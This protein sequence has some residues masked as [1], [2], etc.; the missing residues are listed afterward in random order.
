M[1]Q[2]VFAISQTCEALGITHAVICPG[3][4]SAPLVFAFTQQKNITC[5]TVIDERSAAYMALGMAQ[6]LRKP[7]ALI[8]TSGTAALNFY[9][10][11]AEAFYQRIPLLVLTADRPPHL[12]HQQDGQMID[13]RNVYGTHARGSYVLP[14]YDHGKENLKETTVIVADAIA[15]CSS[16]AT[17]PVHINVPLTEPLYPEKNKTPQLHEQVSAWLKKTTEPVVND[18]DFDALERAWIRSKK[19]IIIVGL[20]VIQENWITPLLALREHNDVVILAD[21]ASNQ[22]AMATTKLF[23][24]MIGAADPDILKQLEPDLVVSLGGP[25]LSKSLKLWLKKQQPVHFRIQTEEELIN[26]YQHR[27]QTI[28]AK[29]EHVLNRLASIEWKS[30]PEKIFENTW[31]RASVAYGK[32]AIAFTQQITWSELHATSRILQAIPDGSNL[33][34]SN[35][36]V[37]RYASMTGEWNDSWIINSNRGTS[38]IDG[39][40]STAVGAAIANN[41]QTVLITGDLGFLYD[42][43]A[44]WNEHVPPNLRIVVLNNFG[45]GIFTLIDGPSQHKQQLP[46][47]TTPHKQL[48]KA[49]ALQNGLDYYFCD[50]IGSLEKQLKTFFEPYNKAAVLELSFNMKQNASVFKAFKKLKI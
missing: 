28:Y 42:R 11:V 46:Y 20:S 1:Q 30:T 40:T 25:V 23:D 3:S 2:H 33:H 45:G 35:S 29:P 6:Q 16:P 32:K 18:A 17:G 7:V 47:F 9:P 43:N 36:S 31:Q 19:R 4:R 44:L 24:G 41:R 14:C 8:C 22:H 39:C 21:V 13:Q 48:V 38:G 27:L 26:T 15:R 34:L 49:T 37:I 50:S 5:Y 10:A 12:L